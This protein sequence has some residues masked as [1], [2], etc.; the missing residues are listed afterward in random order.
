MAH[1]DLSRLCNCIGRDNSN[2]VNYEDPNF[3]C[4][5]IHPDGTSCR[6]VRWYEGVFVCFTCGGECQICERMES[7]GMVK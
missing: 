6:V 7:I 4:K 5:R 1:A 2:S 3:V